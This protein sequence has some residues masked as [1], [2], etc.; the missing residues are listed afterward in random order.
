M[1]D[2]NTGI[3]LHLQ[4]HLPWHK[5]RIK[6]LELLIISLVRTRTVVYSINAV[7]LNDRAICSNLRRIQRFFSAFVIDY[8]IIAK[9]LMSLNPVK[10]PYK[11]SLDRTNWKFAGINYNIL[12]L[13]IVA[14]GVSL[15]IL[16]TM[17]D[18]RGNSNQDER[19][20]LIMRYIRLFGLAS[21]ECLIADREF[22]GQEWIE[23][24][25]TQPIKF[26]LRIRENLI[27][28]QKGQV[29]KAFWLFNNLPLNQIR[30][31]DKPIKINGQ[32]IYLT[33]MK[34]NKLKESCR[35]CH[36]GNLSFRPSDYEDLRAT[37]DY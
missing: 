29:L 7:S 21:I 34:S 10:R 1:R 32:W 26:Y 6:F 11:L 12:C 18:K 20:L 8:D 3:D 17:L 28:S 23:F 24:L 14:D 35:I 15:P 16:W 2:K 13:T 19:K 4:A 5:A 37:M 36:R 27:V 30:S 31:L 22:I 33:A 25:S 9:I